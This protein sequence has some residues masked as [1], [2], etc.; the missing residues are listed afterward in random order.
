MQILK[1]V[2]QL[3]FFVSIVAYIINGNIAEA[4]VSFGLACFNLG[5]LCGE[6]GRK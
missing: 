6:I 3:G 5:I 2:V 1:I 4:I